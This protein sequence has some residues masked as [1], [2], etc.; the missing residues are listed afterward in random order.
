MP[1]IRPEVV[2]DTKVLELQH[3]RLV[4]SP[5]LLNTAFE[6]AIRNLRQ[7]FVREASTP[8]GAHEQPTDFETPKQRR[9]F[10]WAIKNKVIQ[11][12]GRGKGANPLEKSWKT[13][14]KTTNEGGI[15]RA[16]STAPH[17]VFVQGEHVQRMHRNVWAQESDLFPKYATLANEVLKETWFTISDPTAGIRP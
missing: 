1:V 8:K 16:W 13:D 12:L 5:K 2:V 17:E 7:D 9:Y 14:L 6:R 3:D 11:W 10:F 15:F 4:Q